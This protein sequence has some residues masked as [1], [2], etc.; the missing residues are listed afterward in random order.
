MRDV[1]IYAHDRESAG[2][3]GGA[4][5]E[6]GF[7]PRHVAAGDDLVPSGRDGGRVRPP[8][9]AMVVTAPGRPVPDDL[10]GRLRATEPLQHVPLL[11]AVD[12]E[13]LR[14]CRDTVRAH[15]LLVKPFSLEE[16]E[17]RVDWATN[18][19]AKA[20]SSDLIR[21]GSL[22]LNLATYQVRVAER[23]VAFAYMEYE[24]LKFLA[25]HPNRVF[26]REALLSRVWGYEYYGGARTVDVHVR[27]VRAKLGPEH[28]A[29]VKTVRGVGY[30][31]EAQIPAGEA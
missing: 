17:A 29:R 28:A 30:L 23:T 26:S 27:R 6:L 31:F 1:W 11:F 10:V 7:G 2:E 13:H 12:P 14:A 15:E 9:L 3:V 25:T 16:L 18:D 20:E 5:A 8:A 21:I 24:L 22:E 4:L 19:Q